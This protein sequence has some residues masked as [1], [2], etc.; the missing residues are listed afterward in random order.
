MLACR[1]SPVLIYLEPKIC[2]AVAAFFP[3]L[4]Q[5]LYLLSAAGSVVVE[6]ALD[7]VAGHAG[8]VAEV[9]FE[10]FP[11][12]GRLL[13]QAA[14]NFVIVAPFGL[15]VGVGEEEPSPCQWDV[16]HLGGDRCRNEGGNEDPT[17]PTKLSEQLLNR[18]VFHV[19]CWGWGGGWEWT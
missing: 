7:E 16:E 4:L 13:A 10:S 11:A 19:N 5:I 1:Y 9:V 18:C 3:P 6:I 15:E 12:V 8:R 14:A 2:R 17:I